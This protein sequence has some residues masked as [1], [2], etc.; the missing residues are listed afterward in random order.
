[1]ALSRWVIEELTGMATASYLHP[2]AE[3]AVGTVHDVGHD[4]HSVV[5]HGI[6]ALMVWTRAT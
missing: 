6:G 4:A 5:S 2:S 3:R 1:M